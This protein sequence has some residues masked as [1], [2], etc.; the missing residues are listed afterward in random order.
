M[1]VVTTTRLMSPQ[2]GQLVVHDLQTGVP[3]PFS[4][5]LQVLP[6]DH[7]AHATPP[8]HRV[9]LHA[10]H[11]GAVSAWQVMS[12]GSTPATNM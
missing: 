5:T 8:A 11:Q 2:G 10:R 3:V 12:H 4:L 1:W 6:A 7:A 9:A